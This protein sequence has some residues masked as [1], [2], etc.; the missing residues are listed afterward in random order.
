[1]Q[2]SIQFQISNKS[3][4]IGKYANTIS[5]LHGKNSFA[6]VFKNLDTNLKIILD[7]QNNYVKCINIDDNAAKNFNILLASLRVL[8]NYFDCSNKIIF[9]SISS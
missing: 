3:I 2:N 5:F 9:R 1:M 7:H 8:H 6:E 4:V